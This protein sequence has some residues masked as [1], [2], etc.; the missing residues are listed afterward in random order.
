MRSRGTIRCKEVETLLIVGGDSQKSFALHA[1]GP[2]LDGLVLFAK[3]QDV[4]TQRLV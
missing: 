4:P 2:T 3:V 1:K